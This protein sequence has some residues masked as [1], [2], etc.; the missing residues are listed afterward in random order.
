MAIRN[1]FALLVY[2]LVFSL[3]F[4]IFYPM[5][6]DDQRGHVDVQ[7]RE[8]DKGARGGAPGNSVNKAS[9][10]LNVAGGGPLYGPA[11]GGGGGGAQRS[12]QADTPDGRPIRATTEKPTLP[13]RS[14]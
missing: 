2:C 3:A 14:W 7:P 9:L 4:V 11:W 12:L 5:Y 10:V 13:S 1:L 8:R 6:A